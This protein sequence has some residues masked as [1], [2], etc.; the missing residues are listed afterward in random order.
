MW[1]HIPDKTS[2]GDNFDTINH[3]EFSKGSIIF[4]GLNL[5]EI[6]PFKK[7]TIWSYNFVESKFLKHP[8]KCITN[9]VLDEEQ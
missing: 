7:K 4:F 5:S 2:N 1:L 8:Q 3:L 6:S 9:Q